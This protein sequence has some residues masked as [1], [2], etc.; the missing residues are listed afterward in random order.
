ME[1]DVTLA[2]GLYGLSERSCVCVCVCVCVCLCVCV[3]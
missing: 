2:C 1:N 3:C